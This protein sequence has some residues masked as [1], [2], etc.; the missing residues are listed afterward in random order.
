MKRNRTNGID[1]LIK[2]EFQNVVNYIYTINSIIKVKVSS[3]FVII[4]DLLKPK[5]NEWLNNSET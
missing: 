3:N 2:R 5:V 1:L 4:S